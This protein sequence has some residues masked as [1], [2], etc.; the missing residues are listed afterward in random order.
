MKV[1]ILMATLA[2]SLML[3]V[4]GFANPCDCAGVD[5]CGSCDRFAAKGNL[6]SGLKRLVNGVH[7]ANCDPCD[8]VLACNPCDAAACDPCDAVCDVPRLGLGGR[9]RNLLATSH[10]T[11]CDGAGNCFDGCE[12]CNGA[13]NCFDGCDPCG[14]TNGCATPRFSLRGL[15]PFRGLLNRGCFDGCDPCNGAQD[16]FDKCSPCDVTGNGCFDGCDPCNGAQ[17]CFD[18][19]GDNGCGP[20]GHLFDLPRFKLSKLFG[21]V[22]VNR[23]DAGTCGP[24]DEVRPCDGACCR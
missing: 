23:C 21:K 5:P 6:F 20:R 1:R 15:N 11:P 16:C 12:P 22:C 7:V 8:A 9:L 4:Q 13:Q 10:C 2:V 17:N 18:G 3:G 24:C 19:C 14:E